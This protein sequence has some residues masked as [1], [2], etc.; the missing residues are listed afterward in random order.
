VAN[1]AKDIAGLML[2]RRMEIPPQVAPDV[3]SVV[4]RAIDAAKQARN[5]INELDE[6]IETGFRG[7]EV[8]VVQS[9]IKKLDKIETDTDEQQV[10]LRAALFELED[11]LAPVKVMFLYQVIDW[12]GA[13]ADLSQRV[14]SRL[15]Y[16]LAR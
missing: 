16:L 9:M 11:S 2:G 13:V 4:E 15:E 6:L 8:D 10:K 5:A 3:I 1:R 14:G 7:T 12:I